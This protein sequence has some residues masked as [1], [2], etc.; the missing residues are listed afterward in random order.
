MDL[1]KGAGASEDDAAV[2]LRLLR[3]LK[4][5]ELRLVHKVAYICVIYFVAF[6]KICFYSSVREYLLR[7]LFNEKCT[8]YQRF[9]ISNKIL[10][11]PFSKTNIGFI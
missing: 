3:G 6:G 1:M 9:F 8:P 11:K 2:W 5:A 4:V 10:R 7:C